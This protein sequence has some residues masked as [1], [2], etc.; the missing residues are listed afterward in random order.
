MMVL[1]VLLC[2]DLFVRLRELPQSAG[3]LAA[4][5]LGESAFWLLCQRMTLCALLLLSGQ[6]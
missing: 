5:S 2:V 3:K 1:P 4:S 6:Q